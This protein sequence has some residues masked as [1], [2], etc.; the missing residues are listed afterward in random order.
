MA[1]DLATALHQLADRLDTLAPSARVGELAAV[2][3]QAW[4][5]AVPVSPQ[6]PAPAQD[7]LLDVTA[8]A[9]LLGRS[10]SWMRKHGRTL[11]GFV[12]PTGQGGRVRWSRAALLAWRD[13]LASHT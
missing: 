5:T 8:A 7:G 1:D 10:A 3:F 9:A 2:L 12:Q 13:R 11:P 6:A 4:I